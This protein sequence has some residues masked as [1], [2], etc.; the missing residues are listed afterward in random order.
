VSQHFDQADHRQAGSV[1][2]RSNPGGAQAR[3]GTTEELSIGKQ[4][5]EASPA[6]IRILRIPPKSTVPPCYNRTTR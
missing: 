3:P 6:D 2:Y 5:S 4:Q 1:Y